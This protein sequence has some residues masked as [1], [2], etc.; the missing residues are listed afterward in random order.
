MTQHFAPSR[1]TTRRRPA[2]APGW[3]GAPPAP[4]QAGWLRRA[5]HA[6]ARWWR[7]RWMDDMTAYLSQ[8]ESHADLEHRIREWNDRAGTGGP[9]LR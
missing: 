1:P 8:A 9:W 6:I 7:R 2:I 4:P 5:G 3:L